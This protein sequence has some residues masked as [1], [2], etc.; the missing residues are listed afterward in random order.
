MDSL[1]DVVQEYKVAFSEAG[2]DDATADNRYVTGTGDWT[3]KWETS[4]CVK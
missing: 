3:G 2:Q 4:M 1:K